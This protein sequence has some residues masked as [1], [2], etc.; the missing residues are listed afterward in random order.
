VGVHDKQALVLINKGN[1]KGAEVA[2]LS[3]LICESVN[4][5]FGIQ[6]YPEVIFL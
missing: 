2:D 6:I 4:T 5:Q 3:A 1:A